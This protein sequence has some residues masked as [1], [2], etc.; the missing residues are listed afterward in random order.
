M[1]VSFAANSSETVPEAAK[2][3]SAAR[4]AA[5]LATSYVVSPTLGDPRLWDEWPILNRLL[6][7]ANNMWRGR[8]NALQIGHRLTRQGQRFPKWDHQF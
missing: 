7:G 1:G 5:R 3:T 6:H 8:Q 2:A 4:K